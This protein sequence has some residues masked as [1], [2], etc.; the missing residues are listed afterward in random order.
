MDMWGPYAWENSAFIFDHKN[1]FN[2]DHFLHP[3][4]WFPDFWQNVLHSRWLLHGFTYVVP[5]ETLRDIEA[6]KFSLAFGIKYLKGVVKEFCAHVEISKSE[7]P[8]VPPLR[9][10]VSTARANGRHEIQWNPSR[11]VLRKPL[12]SVLKNLNVK[13]SAAKDALDAMPDEGSDSD[14]GE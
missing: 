9:R 2:E 4:V 3:C 8:E 1:F 11:R 5:E 14:G 10:F 13:S 7:N 12:S 6:E